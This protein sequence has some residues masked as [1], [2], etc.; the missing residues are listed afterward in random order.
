MT[1]LALHLRNRLIRS[2]PSTTITSSTTTT[3][4]AVIAKSI[5][6]SSIMEDIVSYISLNVAHVLGWKKKDPCGKGQDTYVPL[7]TYS[8]SNNSEHYIWTHCY[9]GVDSI[10]NPN[11]LLME[12]NTRDSQTE[13]DTIVNVNHPN[14][15]TWMEEEEDFSTWL[16]ST[17]KRRKKKMN[18]HKLQKRRKRERLSGNKK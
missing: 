1:S 8:N 2:Q 11:H 5:M 6:A 3:T 4:T 15:P 17:L 13:V 7:S 14:N 9:N 16:I 12:Y 18:K 10:W